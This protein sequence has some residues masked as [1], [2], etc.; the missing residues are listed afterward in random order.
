MKI[1][2]IRWKLIRKPIKINPTGSPGPLNPQAL[3][4]CHKL[5][6][7]PKLPGIL[8]RLPPGSLSPSTEI[9]FWWT[10]TATIEFRRRWKGII[11]C[12]SLGTRAPCFVF[13]RRPPPSLPLKTLKNKKKPLKN[14]YF[15][16]Q[17]LKKAI[18]TNEK[19]IF[20]TPGLQNFKQL[21]KN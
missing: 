6:R 16:P 3:R 21:K 14:Q 20:S 9:D 1:N 8:L 5:S 2:E 12:M 4:G 11:L 18:K 19:S 10:Q 7:L 15:R 13:F 17:N